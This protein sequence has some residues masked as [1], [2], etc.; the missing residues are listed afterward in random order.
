V[1]NNGVKL[2]LT[3]IVSAK[4]IALNNKEAFMLLFATSKKI[5][6]PLETILYNNEE[7]QSI[8]QIATT[9]TPKNK[10]KY[11]ASLSSKSLAGT[12]LVS[13]FDRTKNEF[14]ISLKSNPDEINNIDFMIYKDRGLSFVANFDFNR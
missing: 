1:S 10:L 11:V 7:N 6:L 8:M 13:I 3:E 5:D 2:V 4:Y 14:D 12:V 9:T